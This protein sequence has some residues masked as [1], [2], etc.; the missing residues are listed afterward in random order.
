MAMVRTVLS[1]VTTTHDYTLNGGQIFSL[2]LESD[3]VSLY[4][5]VCFGR[6]WHSLSIL[7]SV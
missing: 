4:L 6:K 7:N 3:P 5:F 1:A 2:A